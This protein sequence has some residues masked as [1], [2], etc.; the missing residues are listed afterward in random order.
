MI[1]PLV[2][3]NSSPF[4]K[5]Y[6]HYGAYRMPFL[7]LFWFRQILFA[8]PTSYC[9]RINYIFILP[10]PLCILSGL[11]PTGFPTKI[12]YAIFFPPSYIFSTWCWIYKKKTYSNVGGKQWQTTPKNLPRMQRTRAI[13]VTWLN[14]GLCPDRPK[15][16]IPIINNNSNVAG[17]RY[18]IKSL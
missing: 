12:L 3:R 2:V 7:L 5:P 11:L 10:R 17:L 1:V 9:P 6:V 4:T 13:P 8:R 15:G 18:S 14:S 16:W